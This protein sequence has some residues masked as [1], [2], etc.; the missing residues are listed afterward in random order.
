MIFLRRAATLHTIDPVSK[1]KLSAKILSG[2]ELPEEEE[3]EEEEE[4]TTVEDVQVA[5]RNMR[6]TVMFAFGAAVAA[7]ML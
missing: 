3:E 6:W 5:K 4:E 2:G 7:L 1:R